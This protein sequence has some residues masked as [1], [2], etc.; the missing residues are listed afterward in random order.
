MRRFPLFLGSLL[1]AIGAMVPFSALAGTGD[2]YGYPYYGSA[3][4]SYYTH[5]NP[6]IAY[7]N[8][9]PYQYPCQFPYPGSSCP[10]PP[11]FNYTALPVITNISGPQTVSRGQSGTWY[12]T[13]SSQGMLRVTVTP[14]WSDPGTED[15]NANPQEYTVYGTQTFAFSH[16]YYSTGAFT[17]R[18]TLE[19]EYGRRSVRDTTVVV[20]EQNYPFYASGTYYPAFPYYFSSY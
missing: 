4:P 11:Q 7:T 14:A 8:Y 10:T 3:Y 18:F 17:L 15:T 1:L 16:T 5:Y 19:D 13:I 2:A 12:V 9:G 20:S 6:Y